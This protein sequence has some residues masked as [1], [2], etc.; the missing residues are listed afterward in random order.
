MVNDEDFYVVSLRPQKLH[1]GASV[2][3]GKSRTKLARSRRL[4]ML[5]SLAFAGTSL[6]ILRTLFLSLRDCPIIAEMS[7]R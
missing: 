1:G 6:V 7:Y 2:R 3:V 4:V 5:G